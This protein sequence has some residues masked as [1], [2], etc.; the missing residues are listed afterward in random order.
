MHD[1][2]QLVGKDVAIGLF[3]KSFVN[4][5]STSTE[6]NSNPVDNTTKKKL[7]N[8]VFPQVR[9]DLIGTESKGPLM[10]MQMTMTELKNLAM[11]VR[12]IA[13]FMKDMNKYELNVS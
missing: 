10:R 6:M 9:I 7:Q 4:M 11:K 3:A 1:E 2:M 12:K 5:N 13:N 8:V